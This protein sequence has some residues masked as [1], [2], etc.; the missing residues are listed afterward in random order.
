MPC[1]P[2]FVTDYSMLYASPSTTCPHFSGT[3][4]EGSLVAAEEPQ[5]ETG[6]GQLG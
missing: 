4:G 5:D 1:S 6:C 2:H 3:L